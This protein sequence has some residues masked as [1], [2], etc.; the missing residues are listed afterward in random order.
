M[1]DLLV[2]PARRCLMRLF[3]TS[4]A[5]L[6]LCSTSQ[7]RFQHTDLSQRQVT[8]HLF[9]SAARWESCER[10]EEITVAV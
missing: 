8:R 4:L 9:L 2:V 1:L 5:R 3:P 7:S 6:L 10:E